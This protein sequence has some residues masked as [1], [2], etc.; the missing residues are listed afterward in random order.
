MAI[1]FLASHQ[2]SP[3]PNDSRL[4]TA[5]RVLVFLLALGGC[6]TDGVLRSVAAQ[7]P[8]AI[9]IPIDRKGQVDGTT[10]YISPD[11]YQRL[12]SPSASRNSQYFE[13]ISATH[14]VTL[15]AGLQRS[16]LETLVTYEFLIT[17]SD[18]WIR[19]PFRHPLNQPRP[20]RLLNPTTRQ[21]QQ[22]LD[23]SQLASAKHW[24]TTSAKTIL[25]Q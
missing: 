17:N 19:L 7:P 18:N 11:L 3:F 25:G 2:T 6:S 4:G 15:L 8:Q 9:L 24:L 14:Q 22:R 20:R 12:L 16:T 21:D 13:V 1:A 5:T 10:A 23:E